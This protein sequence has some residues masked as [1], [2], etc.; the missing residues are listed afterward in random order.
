MSADTFALTMRDQRSQSLDEL[1]GEVFDRFATVHCLAVAPVHLQLAVD[2]H[3][4]DRQ[5][6]GPLIIRTLRWTTGFCRG[7]ELTATKYLIKLAQV[8]ET[9]FRCRL[10]LAF[11]SAEIAPHAIADAVLRHSAQLLFSGLQ[12][13]REVIRVQL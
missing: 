8:V 12:R 11:S 9:D 13:A 7:S 10:S 3:A 5:Q 2:D 6:V 1:R 4:A